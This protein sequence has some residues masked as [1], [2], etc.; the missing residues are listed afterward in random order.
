MSDMIA[1]D[2]PPN[3]LEA[4][5]M[6]MTQNRRFKKAPMFFSAARGMYYETPDGRRV[7]D[8]IAGL[9]CVNAGHCH[10]KVVEAIRDQAGKLDYASSFGLGHPLA[11]HYTNRLMTI[12]P[13]GFNHVFLAGSGSEAVDTALKIALACQRARGQGHSQRL[14][15]RQRSYHG[16]GFGGLSVSGI[17]WHRAQFGVLMPGVSHLPHTHDLGRNAF[18]RGQPD[19]GAEFADALDGI[20]AACDPSTV[21][22]V[23][24]EPV[25]GAGGVLPPPRGYLER[26]RAT[27]DKHGILLIFDEVVTGFGRLGAPFAAQALGVTPDLITCAKGMTN[28]AVP[29]GGVLVRDTVYDSLAQGPEAAVELA[30]GYTYSGHPLACAAA[31]ATLDSYLEEGLFERAKQL[32]PVWEDALHSLRGKPHVRDIRNLGLLGAVEIESA[33]D[34]LGLRA[35]KCADVCFDRGVFVRALGE[36]LVLSPPLIID[37]NQIGEIRDAIAAGLVEAAKL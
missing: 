12:A 33:P 24:V 19:H 29:M 11:F 9:W 16:M 31:L 36:T 17:G 27:C 14:I 15:G 30:H 26:L 6:P 32:A 7:L 22:A 13:D 8:A 4:Y 23:I 3:D 28:G 5:W 20:L 21:A 37:E 1:L 25:A 10:P 34:S 35:R 18:S 2:T